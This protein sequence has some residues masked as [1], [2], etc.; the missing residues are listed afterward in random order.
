MAA[1]HITGLVSLIQSFHPNVSIA[2][3]KQLFAQFSRPVQSDSGKSIASAVDVPR[4]LESFRQEKQNIV[5]PVVENSIISTSQT[6][7]SS[8]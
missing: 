1:P 2:E 6:Q 5:M 4:L 8:S 7:E 3:I